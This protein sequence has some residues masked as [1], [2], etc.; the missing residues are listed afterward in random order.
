MTYTYEINGLTVQTADIVCTT[1]AGEAP[2]SG[3]FW[4][5]VGMLIPGAVDHVAIYVGPKGRCV[6]AG[7]KLRVITF[8]I[9]DGIWDASEMTR[10]RGPLM[11][12][13]YGVAYPLAGRR[14]ARQKELEIRESVV[15]YCLKQAKAKKPYNLNFLD[16]ET[17]KAFYCSQLA[18]KAYI[19]EGI[20]L[21]TGKGVPSIPGTQSIVF[22]QEIWSGCRHKRAANKPLA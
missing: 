8:S 21:N 12:T 10:S 16:S 17:E 9:K 2:I 5:L 19:R 13:F 4:R 1:N 20:N 7:A 11:D 3:Q 15:R 18:Y 14:I 22:P 6:E